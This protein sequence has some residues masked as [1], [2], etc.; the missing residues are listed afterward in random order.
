VARAEGCSPIRPEAS[1][2]RVRNPI[3]LKNLRMRFLPFYAGGL[4]LFFWVR[5]APVEYVLGLSAVLVGVALRAWG[6]GHLVKTTSLSVTGPY[7]RMRH[8]LYVGTLLC[9]SGIAVMLGGGWALLVLG[10]FLPWFFLVYFPRKERLE[11]ERLAALYGEA[12]AC[13]R[14]E[15]PA[16]LPRLVAWTPSPQAVP[17]ADASRRWSLDLY[18]Q[19][20]ELGTFLALLACIALFGIRMVGW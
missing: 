19:N 3:R 20:N 16:L 14:S 10:L 1:V 4:V 15:V 13:Y 12:F 18:W 9:G 5:P 2:R 8:P 11:S 17:R 7:A 6:A